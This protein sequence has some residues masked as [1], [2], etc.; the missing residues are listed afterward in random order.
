MN[1]TRGLDLSG[2][3]QFKASDLLQI[4]PA[5]A[6]GKP[7]QVALSLID[8]DPKQ[9]RRCID[10]VLIGELA[11]SIKLYG[12]LEPVSLRTDPEWIG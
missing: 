3:V 9:P 5:V 10:E 11:T 1:A 6:I 7:V 4:D 2:L 12:V 8:F